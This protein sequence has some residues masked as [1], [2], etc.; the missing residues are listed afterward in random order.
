MHFAPAKKEVRPDKITVDW[1]PGQVYIALISRKHN[2][3]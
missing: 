2:Q 3:T 1:E